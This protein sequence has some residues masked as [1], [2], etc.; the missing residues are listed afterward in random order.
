MSYELRYLVLTFVSTHMVLAGERTLR[1]S[2]LEP[3]F[4]PV[5]REIDSSCGFCLRLALPSGSAGREAAFAS[6]EG[7]AHETLWKIFE[8]ASW[9]ER[10]YERI[11][12]TD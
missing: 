8:G 2:G 11:A 9:K 12:E 7:V 5:P 3:E 4:I 1:A 6:A 10:R